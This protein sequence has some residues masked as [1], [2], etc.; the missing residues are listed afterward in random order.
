MSQLRQ[1]LPGFL[2]ALFSL[3]FVIGG[4][5]MAL[6]DGQQRT[7]AVFPTPMPTPT[8]ATPTPTVVPIIAPTFTPL[9][10][11]AIAAVDSTPTPVP[12]PTN[13]LIP[14]R[15]PTISGVQPTTCPIPGGWISHTV[16][17]GETLNSLAAFYNTTVE[18]LV[19]GNCIANDG[20]NIPTIIAGI[21][22]FVPPTQFTA[23]PSRTPTITRT[24]LPCGPYAGWIRY[25]VQSGDTL[26]SLARAFQ[27]TTSRLQYANCLGT[28]TFIQAGQRI[29]VPNRATITPTPTITLT[30]S[31]TPTPTRTPTST[32]TFTP[33]PPSST[34]IPPSPTPT[35]VPPSATPT[36]SPT[37]APPTPT[38][39]STATPVPPTPTPTGTNTP[40]AAS[41]T[42]APSETPTPTPTQTNTP[43]PPTSTNTPTATSTP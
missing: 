25:T 14:T 39:T 42:S 15:T 26:F 1:V 27:T 24:A 21:E 7:A 8:Q 2:V 36:N 16:Q 38:G 18:Q 5:S 9:P 20:V 10:T 4:V 29:Y 43:V 13:T 11:L 3:V 35:M 41:P 17:A 30:P 22:L 37:A 33:V 34:P 12:S 23:T 6:L 28:S 31:Q 40:V 19:Q 32:L